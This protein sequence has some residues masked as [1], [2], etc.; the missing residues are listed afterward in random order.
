MEVSGDPGAAPGDAEARVEAM[1]T[2]VA[3]LGVVAARGDGRIAYASPGI[4]DVVGFE[5]DE[6]VGSNLLDHLHPDDVERALVTITWR[7]DEGR[8]PPGTTVFRVRHKAVGYV[9]VEAAASHFVLDE[10]DYLAIYVRPAVP[11]RVAEDLLTVVVR[12][13]SRVESLKAT[14]DSISWAEHGSH[15]AIVWPEPEGT[16]HVSTG[17]PVA[18]TGVETGGPSNP[19]NECLVTGRE[20]RRA[21]E[22]LDDDTAELAGTMGLAEMWV[23]PV[24]WSDEEEPALVT[25]WSRGGIAMPEIHGYGMRMACKFVELILR[26]TAPTDPSG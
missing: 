17:L 23:E 19:W 7:D 2:R 21:L 6:L 24:V 15:V 18:L 14:L 5:R 13:S 20:V 12:G 16:R 10:E 3:P 8:P 11:Q 4:T 22:E 1:L 9:D 25:V 26:S